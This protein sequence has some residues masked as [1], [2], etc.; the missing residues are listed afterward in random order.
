MF[1]YNKSISFRSVAL[2][3]SI[4]EQDQ[5]AKNEMRSWLK[6]NL[7]DKSA[8]RYAGRGFEANNYSKQDNLINNS[9]FYINIV[10][11][12]YSLA[13]LRYA[14]SKYKYSLAKLRYS[15]S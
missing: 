8:K 10:V 13:K 3:R 2:P 5:K 6:Y 9:R 11:S 12:K 15:L 4:H 14:F 1:K 7:E